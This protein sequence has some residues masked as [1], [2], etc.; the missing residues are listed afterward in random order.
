[1]E[2]SSPFEKRLVLAI[3]HAGDEAGAGAVV[4]LLALD[5][6][7][8]SKR[9]WAANIV[10]RE[11]VTNLWRHGGGG[12]LRVRASRTEGLE[13][14]S[15]NSGSAIITGRAASGSGYGLGVI[16]RLADSMVVAHPPAGGLVVTV[17][18]RCEG[19]E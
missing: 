2:L 18:M 17:L 19:G 13:L 3:E 10:A 8:S 6:G 5:C 14:V 11:L 16:Q 15:E 12:S 1:M 9:A 7:F 4:R